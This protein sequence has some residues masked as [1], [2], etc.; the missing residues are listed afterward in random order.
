M[1]EDPPPLFCSPPSGHT[2]FDVDQ[3]WP[4]TSAY[5]RQDVFAMSGLETALDAAHRNAHEYVEID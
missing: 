1:S 5:G 3:H 4:H 2:K